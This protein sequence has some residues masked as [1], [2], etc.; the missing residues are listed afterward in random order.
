MGRKGLQN[1]QS[2]LEKQ[3]QSENLKLVLAF[4]LNFH[5]STGNLM[6]IAR[7]I[8]VKIGY[9]NVSI[10]K[11]CN[12]HF[13]RVWFWDERK[14]VSAQIGRDMMK[15]FSRNFNMYVKVKPFLF[16]LQIFLFRLR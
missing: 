4:T 16:I 2:R 14:H 10:Q 15:V 6:R 7:A 9:R 1:T 3:H 11:E 8:L 13:E 12:G 5:I